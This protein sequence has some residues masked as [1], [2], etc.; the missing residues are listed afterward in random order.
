MKIVAEATSLTSSVM[1]M[2]VTGLYGRDP[3]ALFEAV[4][5]KPA[6]RVSLL[7]FCQLGAPLC[8]AECS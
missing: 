1:K 2:T 4:T 6:G 7:R 3:S 5:S 8:C